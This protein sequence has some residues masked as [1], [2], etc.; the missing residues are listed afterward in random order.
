MDSLDFLASGESLN[1]IFAVLLYVP[2][3]L[4]AYRWLIPRLSPVSRRIASGFLLA[5][6]LVIALSLIVRPTSNTEEWLW[7]LD[8]ARNIPSTLASAQLTLVGVVALTTSWLA[9]E[10]SAWQRLYL[11]GIGLVFPYIA[12][13]DFFDWQLLNESD[14]KEPYILFGAAVVLATIAAAMRWPRRARIWHFWLLAGL[15]L[16]AIGGIVLDSVPEFCGPAGVARD[17]ECLHFR[18][19]EEALEFLGTWLALVAML[20]HFSNAAPLPGRRTRIFLY[21]LPILTALL[22]SSHSLIPHFAKRL[23]GAPALV[24]VEASERQAAADKDRQLPDDTHV[25]MGDS[26]DPASSPTEQRSVPIDRSQVA[27]SNEKLIFAFLFALYVPVGL[28]SYWRLTPHLAAP[29]ARLASAML[30]AQIIVI[31]LAIGLRPASKFETWLWSLDQEWNIPSTLASAQLALVAG[32]A[33]LT[34]WLAKA[35]SVLQRLYLG[36]IGL[37]FLFLAWDE[38]Y[39]FHEGI[40][41]WEG[42]FSALGALVALATVIVAFRGPRRARIWHWCLLTGLAMSAIGGILL[43]GQ[44]PI[45]DRVGFLSLYGCLWPHNYEETLEFLGIWLA[46]VAVLGHLSL[47]VPKPRPLVRRSL[48][49]LP[50]LW[51]LLLVHHA[52]IPQLELR[53]L[54][55]PASVQFESGLR[56]QGYRMDYNDYAYII[57][58]Y[59]SAR[60]RDYVG[61]GFSVHLVDQVSG[62][63]VASRDRHVS[64]QFGLLSAPGYTHVYRQQLAIEPPPRAVANRALS[65]VLTLWHDIDG[66]FLRKKVLSS[67]RQLLSE[68]QVLLGELVLPAKSP[69]PTTPPVAQFANGFA[70]GPVDLPERAHAGDDLVI[71]FAWHSSENGQEDHVQFLHLGYVSPPGEGGSVE[72]GAQSVESAAWFVYDQEPL[73]P[74][75]PTRLWYSGLGDSETWQVPLPADLAPGHYQVF[76]GLYRTRDQE[77]VPAT[78]ADGT[79][80]VDARVPLG[81]LVIE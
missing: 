64:R 78:D 52:F 10:R 46:L 58:L 34:A 43:N 4:I 59:P 47:A 36:G 1:R 7:M 62:D 73:G 30:A 15:A 67:D 32:A 63:S 50:A 37:L 48:Y 60:R 41:N 65:V 70:L 55:E 61:K 79:A 20:G 69:A 22:F 19:Q 68:T 75:L 66:D 12:L 53:F 38:Y 21:A 57:R 13:D 71:L 11:L 25:V 72:G 56:L 26:A 3:C 6:M 74:R 24:Q 35:R 29:Y 18:F 28:V 49:L 16:T 80:F 81:A 5:Q 31:V 76:T 44:P 27:V 77:R 14:I 39:A 42:Y 45:C 17:Y 8:H 23:T 2:A 9:R 40:A 54:A 51:I 33:L